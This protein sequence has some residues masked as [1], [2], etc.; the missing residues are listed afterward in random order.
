MLGTISVPTTLHLV[1]CVTKD[2]GQVHVAPRFAFSRGKESFPMTAKPHD[3]GSQCQPTWTSGHRDTQE[4]QD[5]PTKYH[6]DGKGPKEQQL[7][8]PALQSSYTRDVAALI[9]SG[10]LICARNSRVMARGRE[11]NGG[12]WHQSIF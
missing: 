2:F 3:P 6:Q 1:P 7:I 9:T 11:G 10:L 8:T 4:H 12:D 5:K